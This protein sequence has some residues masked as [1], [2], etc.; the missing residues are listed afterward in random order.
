MA[1]TLVHCLQRISHSQQR[2]NVL[3]LIIQF[4]YYRCIIQIGIIGIGNFQERLHSFNAFL[5]SQ[6]PTFFRLNGDDKL[7]ETI[8]VK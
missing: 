7:L 5:S 2:N 3:H 8:N 1:R 4:T 6:C